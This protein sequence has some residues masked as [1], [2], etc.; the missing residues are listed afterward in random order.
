MAISVEQIHAQFQHYDFCYDW[1]LP[2]DFDYCVD[3]DTLP[4][5]TLVLST[6]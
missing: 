4:V 6:W 1:A 3:S 2:R 5:L